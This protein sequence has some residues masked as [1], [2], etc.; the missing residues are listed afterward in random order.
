MSEDLEL[1][2]RWRDGDADAGD[3]LLRRHF[4]SLFRFFRNKVESG[5][6]DLLQ[7]TMLK[8]IE[9]R[10]QFRGQSSFRTYLFV[11]ARNVLCD[12]LRKRQRSPKAM[13]FSQ[14]SL[15]DLGTTP[16]KAIARDERKRLLTEALHTL[17]L[18]FQIAVELTYWENLNATEVGEV[19]G[20]PANTVRSRLVRARRRLDTHL[21]ALQ[22]G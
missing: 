19:L 17:P 16:S 3:A 22:E 11:V 10:D 18:D 6:D 15:A 20:I 2:D 1:L 7:A 8:C 14:V 13:D 5:V 12:E 9:K 4:E 21:Q